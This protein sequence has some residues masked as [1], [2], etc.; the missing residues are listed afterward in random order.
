MNRAI[1]AIPLLAAC[2]LPARS[3]ATWG[4]ADRIEVSMAPIP[5]YCMFECGLD[6]A[7]MTGTSEHFITNGVDNHGNDSGTTQRLSAVVDDPSVLDITAQQIEL[8]CDGG[9]F[10]AIYDSEA[11]CAA[12]GGTPD[13]WR[14]YFDAT[15]VGAGETT[16]RFVDDEGETFDS[17][18]ITVEDPVKLSVWELV[19]PQRYAK[20]DPV[21]F[22]VAPDP[23]IM[24][25]R[26]FG[27]GGNPLQASTGITVAI[28]DAGTA[29]LQESNQ[30]MFELVPD[31]AGETALTL[32]AGDVSAT[33]DVVVEY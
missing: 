12:S 8:R 23:L 6:W 5:A 7:L 2:G 24:D 29:H 1:L 20:R 30:A 16:I 4:D 17:V 18:D 21:R 31:E 32:A 10:A 11:E 28:D 3:E 33:V 27:K 14:L 22:H 19:S 9:T 15:A 25:A 13:S 26:A